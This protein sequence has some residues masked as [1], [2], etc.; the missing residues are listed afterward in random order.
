MDFF[1]KF[2]AN[3]LPVNQII[4]F[5]IKQFLSSYLIIKENDLQEKQNEESGVKNLIDINDLELNVS[6]INHEHLLHSPIKLLKGKLGKFSLDITDENKIIIT[7]EDVSIDLMPLFNYYK[8]YQ[9]TIFNMQKTKNEVQIESEKENKNQSGTGIEQNPESNPKTQNIYMLNMAN[10]LLTNLEINIKNI[11]IKLFTYEISEKMLENPVFSLFIMNIN[12][13]KDENSQKDKIVII[14]PKTNLPFEE[15][16]LNNLNIEVDKLCIKVDQILSEKD[17]RE[18]KMIKKFCNDKKLSKEQNEKITSF[19]IAYNT[20]FAM[21]YKKGP[22]LSIKLKINPKI[23]KYRENDIYKEKVVEDMNILINIFEAESIITPHQ[24]FNIQILSEI[25]NFIFTLNKNTPNKE[26]ELKEKKDKYKKISNNINNINNNMEFNEENEEEEEKEKENEGSSS[27]IFNKNKKN[28]EEK[29]NNN[30][31][32]ELKI[33]YFPDSDRNKNDIKIP[34][35]EKKNYTEV[36]GHEFPKFNISMNCKRIILVLLENNNN[37]S[38]PKLFS[39]LMEEEILSKKKNM[40]NIPNSDIDFNNS[41]E[42][43][44]NYYCYFEDNLLFLKIENINSVNTSINISSIITEYIKSNIVKENT[45]NSNKQK[46]LLNKNKKS[47]LEASIYDSA[48]EYADFQEANSDEEDVFESAIENTACLIMENYNKFIDKFIKGEYQYTKLEILIINEIKLDMNENTLDI[49]EILINLNYIIIL[50]YVKLFNQI[51]YFIET[52]RPMYTN[53]DIIQTEDIEENL[54][55]N[56]E[57]KLNDSELQLFKNLNRL[58]KISSGKTDEGD[59][60]NISGNDSIDFSQ[61]EQNKKDGMKIN[62]SYISIKIYNISKNIQRFDTNIYYYKLFLELIYPNITKKIK[63]K[64]NQPIEQQSLYE[65]VSK[66]FVEIVFNNMNMIYYSILNTTKINIIFQNIL[67]KYW[68]Y[69]VIQYNNINKKNNIDENPNIAMTMPNIDLIVDFS[70]KIRINLEKNILDDLLSFNNIFL[71]GLSM[72]Q[73]FDK[74]CG[75]LYNNKLINLFDLFGLKNHFQTL[76]NI[77]NEEQNQNQY[78]NKIINKDKKELQEIKERYMEPSIHIGGK[79]SSCVININKNGTFEEKEGN[80]IK[81]KLVNTGIDLEM[82]SNNDNKKE[83]PFNKLTINTNNI[84]FLIKENSLTKESKPTYHNLF[85]KNKTSKFESTDYFQM[86]FKFRN[87]KKEKDNII[88]EEEDED[89]FDEEINK[90]NITNNMLE[91]N[92]LEISLDKKITDYIAFL[93]N[94]QVQ[95]DNMEMVIDIKLSEIIF[96]SFYHK[97]K[98]LSSTLSDFYI[99]FTTTKTIETLD[100][101]YIQPSDLI[102]LCED[103][104]MF[105]KCDFT[106]NHL[107]MDIFLK[108][109]KDQKNWMRLLLLIDEFKFIFNEKGIS[110]VLENNYIYTMKNF[111]YIYYI[112]NVNKKT[113]YFDIE[114]KINNITR[115]DSYLKRLGYIEQFYIDKIKIDKMEKDLNIKLGDINFFFCK[116][117][118]DFIIEFF[119]V[120]NENYLDKLKNIFSQ[121]TLSSEDS[122]EDVDKNEINKDKNRKEKDKDKIENFDNKNNNKKD[123][124][125][126]ENKK[127]EFLDDFE[128]IDDVFFMDELNKNKKDLKNKKNPT[129]KY[130][131]NN[132]NSLNTIPEEKK[133]KNKNKNLKNDINDDFTI[134]ETKSSLKSKIT[135]EEKEEDCIKYLLEINS[136]HIYFFSGSDFDFQDDPKKDLDLSTF[137]N[138]EINLDN[139]KEDENQENNILEI[140]DNYLFKCNYNNNKRKKILQINRRKKNK[141]RDYTNY[142]LINLINLSIKIVDFSYF[143]FIIGNFFIDDNFEKSQYK[144]IIS[145]QDYSNEVSKFLICKIE[146]IKNKEMN[147]DKDITNLIIN[148]TFPSLDI[149]VDQLPLTFILKILLATNYDKNNE[150]NKNNESDDEDD[151]IGNKNKNEIIKN[152]N[153][154]NNIERINS[155]DSW[156][157]DD[158]MDEIDPIMF[159]NKISIN[160]FNI[161]FH[162]HSHKMS[163]KKIIKKGDWLELLNGLADVTELNLKF[164]NFQKS[165][166]TPFNDTIVELLDFWKND[167]VNKQ[168]ANSVLKGFS[169]TRPFYKLYDGIKDIV[170]QPYISYKKNEGIKK[171]LK[172]GMKNFFVSFSSQGL[173][174]GEKIFRGVKIV[175]FRNTKLSLKKKSLY[176]TWVY[177]INKKQHDYEAHYFKKN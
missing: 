162:Y 126:E 78:T 147:K 135:R 143:D 1:K 3:V 69:V 148:L 89:I 120:F 136:L 44:E 110:I 149:F 163:F 130:L 51:N 59:E 38:I 133:G 154:E 160:T 91:V 118:F 94:N 50:L 138:E 24:L 95:L 56:L 4:K 6:N 18:F 99:D 117:S 81:I 152:D 170:R 19:F 108:E 60:L 75:N 54:N 77:N 36:L 134:I 165:V 62:I 35:Q 55:V 159:I 52:S 72:Y 116:D 21:N 42:S 115:E 80:L 27:G 26:D 166:K 65:L 155:K 61:E 82:F 98:I 177:K 111:D 172:K 101:T 8:K 93:L 13:Y 76:K 14:D 103:R 73:I 92:K 144:N 141:E 53:D 156:N 68:N 47:K 57:K 71:Y 173:F 20:I 79:I 174:F 87:L 66:D 49:K 100:G 122:E 84:F 106:I 167:I 30:N 5:I 102:P 29:I 97:L 70:D 48:N 28:S 83:N 10:K 132:P 109:D 25:S 58:K 107:L 119:G 86:I 40:K 114:D 151:S 37:E 23:E 22:C 127:N 153:K 131:N 137:S 139:V 142:I 168:L 175:T 176:K 63:D 45:E 85:S 88:I 46:T 32:L 161:N 16:F 171:G 164:K 105:I 17:N 12:I 112:T 41:N 113:N 104:I 128:E 31:N 124:I 125:K 11:S 2:L 145:K 9:E 7:I 67:L 140:D 157:E 34:K 64:I 90:K 96:D 15:S 43:F 123:I 39:F 121:E 74:Y 150:D 158:F 33:S 146:M 129:S 169:I